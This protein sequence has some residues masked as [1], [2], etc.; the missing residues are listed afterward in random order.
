MVL[1]IVM[2]VTV[3]DDGGNDAADAGDG[4]DSHRCDGGDDRSGGA[5]EGVI[6]GFVTRCLHHLRVHSFIPAHVLT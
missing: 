5:D 3:G 6:T 4:C 1:R 2:M